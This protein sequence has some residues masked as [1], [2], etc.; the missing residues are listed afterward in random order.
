MK[1]TQ[2][3]LEDGR[4]R[5]HQGLH[6]LAQLIAKQI[7]GDSHLQSLASS[8]VVSSVREPVCSFGTKRGEPNTSSEPHDAQAKAE[9]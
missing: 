8:S 7:R 4:A 1:R 2:V 6:I 9:N 3:N 5:S